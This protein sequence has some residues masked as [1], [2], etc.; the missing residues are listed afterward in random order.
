MF[1]SFNPS[2]AGNITIVLK[3][4]LTPM[5]ADQLG[6]QFTDEELFLTIKQIKPL[7]A[8]GPDGMLALFYQNY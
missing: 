7:V 4:R 3:D 2:D 6:G 8:P 1:T 5:L